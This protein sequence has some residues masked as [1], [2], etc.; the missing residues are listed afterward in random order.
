MHA[1]P[2]RNIAADSPGRRSIR[3]RGYDYS[4]VGAY[5]VTI[6]THDRACIFGN[7]TDGEMRL[8]E[9]GQIAAEEWTKSERVR[10]E[11]ELDEW[12]IM[13]NH[14]HG[15]VWITANHDSRNV[16]ATGR[17]P[18][19]SGPKPRSLGAMVAGFKSA[20]TKR[21]NAVLG[22]PGAPF[23]QRNYYEHVIRNEDTL[24]RVRQYIRDNPSKW[25]DDPDNPANRQRRSG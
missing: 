7:I 9:I 22:T 21:I 19:P 11:I 6:C 2:K 10:D 1:D 4:Q 23:W 12:V 20:A 16:G 14:L 13:P 25:P 15:I 8:N 24:D 17:S 5:F 18:L 3:L